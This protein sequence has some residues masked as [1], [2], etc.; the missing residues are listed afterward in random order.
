MHCKKKNILFYQ[1]MRKN[2]K[3][4]FAYKFEIAKKWHKF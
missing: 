1:G 2:I 3:K 4:K